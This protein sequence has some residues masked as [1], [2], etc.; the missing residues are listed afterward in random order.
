MNK[1]EVGKHLLSYGIEID[2]FLIDGKPLFEYIAEWL[3]QKQELL[4]ELSPLDDLAITWTDDY[5]YE[6]DAR[7]MRYVLNKDKAITPI[8]S[9]PDDFDFTCI[10]VVADVVKYEDKV[11]WNRI[12][13]VNRN[14][15][16]FDEE[17]RSGILYT[18]S[19]SQEDWINYG[20]NIA[21]ETVDSPKW[22]EWISQNW[23]EE[24]FRRRINYTY[25]Y[26]QNEHNIDWFTECAFEFCRTEYDRIVEKC[27]TE[28]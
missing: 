11:I 19:Y 4:K 14:H 28:L 21:L 8:M 22:S 23:S 2:V 20:D 10:V 5:D 16:S 27:Y 6:G 17:K 1:L 24:L 13:R 12:G 7:F 3:D 18:K 9:C 15:E 26:Y 25:P